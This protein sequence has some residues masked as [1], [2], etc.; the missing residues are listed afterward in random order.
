MS[1]PEHESKQHV[2]SLR[3][4]LILVS[5]LV[6]V[7]AVYRL[8]S[9]LASVLASVLLLVLAARLCIA[10]KLPLVVKLL[11]LGVTFFRATFSLMESPAAVFDIY[12]ARAYQ[13]Q[14]YEDCEH[15]IQRGRR[16]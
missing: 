10:V 5:L 11:V 15:S 14:L 13:C 2:T 8:H 3:A 16:S 1:N 7:F 6:V 9:G 4:L 12:M